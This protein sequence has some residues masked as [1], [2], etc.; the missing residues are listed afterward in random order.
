[1][2]QVKSLLGGKSVHGQTQKI[3]ELLSWPLW[4]VE[5]PL[6]GISSGFA[7]DS[8]SDWPGPQSIFCVSQD[9]A[10][11]HTWLLAKMQPTEKAPG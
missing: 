5:L 1:M 4:Q 3:P 6:W 7:L 8:H 10:Y 11:V 9:L 2:K